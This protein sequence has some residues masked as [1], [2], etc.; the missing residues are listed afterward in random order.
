[1]TFVTVACICCP[2]NLVLFS[3][4][5]SLPTFTPPPV[6]PTE[7]SSPTFTPA[8]CVDAAC[9]EACA[10]LLA[11]IVSASE[12]TGSPM[13]TFTGD[14]GSEGDY[15][16]LVRYQVDGD[17]ISGPIYHTAPDDLESYK[18][19]AAAHQAIWELFTTII[20]AEQR[21][22]VDEY[23]IFTDGTH[24]LLAAVE[25]EEYKPDKWSLEVDIID[26]KDRKA[27]AATLLHEFAHLVTLNINQSEPDSYVCAVDYV[28]PGCG[29]PNS[30]VDL[31]YRRFW[32]DI[33]D[34]WSAIN[35]IQNDDERDQKLEEFYFD[36]QSQFLT[37]Y[38]T[39][40]TSEDIAESWTY[41]ILVPPPTG[42]TTA[43]KKIMF[44]YEFP[45][46][47]QLRDQI[48]ARLCGYFLDPANP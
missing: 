37:E 6:P 44:F 28:N 31:F 2:T 19:D 3:S 42:D 22:M 12:G 15:H 39:T 9:Q 43:S 21:Q 11:G 47:A 7:T 27:L 10:G 18:Q 45:E 14:T 48:T 38:A 41:F 20:P 32:V 40:D 24:D 30:Y 36:H 33:F 25:Q 1:V 23:I 16:E 34:E 8:S 4:T 17:T 46:L 26:A 13:K 29:Q 5:P 35:A